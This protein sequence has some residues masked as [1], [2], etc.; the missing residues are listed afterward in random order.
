[1]N[2]LLVEDDVE[3][4][5]HLAHQLR[6]TGHSVDV[7]HDGETGLNMAMSA[8]FDAIILDRRLPRLDGIDVLIDLR[9]ESVA[10]PVL[11]ISALGNLYDRVDG[12]NAGA[13]DYLVK[14]VDVLEVNARLNAITRRPPALRD[15][16]LVTAGGLEVNLSRHRVTWRGKELTFTATEFDIL[17]VLAQHADRVVTRKMLLE[18]VWGYQTE[19]QTNI[20]EVHIRRLRARFLAEGQDNTI[21]NIRNVGYRLCLRD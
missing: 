19:P 14:P 20:I 13:D 21:Q 3:L 8:T 11:M 1:M 16:C 4:A 2:L 5:A 18:A 6:N 15:S 9:N 7:A 10:V 12:L 17:V